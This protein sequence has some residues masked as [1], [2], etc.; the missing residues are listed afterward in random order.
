VTEVL[1]G[2]G[3]TALLLFFCAGLASTALSQQEQL[4]A[5]TNVTIQAQNNQKAAEQLYLQLRAVGLDPKRVYQVRDA[6]L[7]RDQLHISLDDGTIAFTQDVNGRITGAFFEG[8]GEILVV[9]PNQAERASMMLFTGAAILEERF[10][11]AYFR[12]NDDI[13]VELQPDLRPLPDG[14]DF[15]AKWDQTAHNLAEWDALRLFVTFSRFLPSVATEAPRATAGSFS[16]SDRFLHARVQGVKLGSFDAYYDSTASEQ[17]AVAQQKR[18]DTVNY[19]NVWAAFPTRPAEALTAEQQPKDEIAIRSY[20]IRAEVKPP[21]TLRA[22]ASLQ[23]EVLGGGA[24]AL[25]FELS[26]FLKVA[27]VKANG[28]PVELIQNQALEGSQLARRGNDILAVVF[29]QPIRTGQKMEL[30]FSYAGDVLSEAGGGLLYVGAR[31]TWYPNRGLAAADFDLQFQYPPGWTLLATGKRASEEPVKPSRTGVEGEQVSRW[32]TERPIPV[33]GFNL[34]RYTK[35]VAEAGKTT[36]ETYAATGVERSFPKAEPE[37]VVVP[38]VP[39]VRPQPSRTVVVA[40]PPPPSPARNAQVVADTA[41]RAVEFFSQRFGVFPYSTLELTQMPGLVSQGWPGLVFLSS[42]A[43]L[44]PE[45][46]SHL[47]LSAANEILDQQV[48]AHETAHQWWGDLVFW[49]GYRDQWMFEGLASY[50]SLMLLESEN[51]ANFRLAMEKYREDLMHKNKTGAVLKDAGPVTLGVRLSSSEF[52]EG[53]E[54]ISYG[55]GTW[56]FHMLRHIL[57]DSWAAD[58]RKS[59][60]SNQDEVEPFVRAL[61]RVRERYAGKPITTWQLLQVFAEDLPESDR[62]EG[63]KSLDWFYGGWVNG[64]ALP[65]FQLQGVRMTTKESSVAVSGTILQKDA[66]KELVTSVPIYAAMPGDRRVFLG[67]VFAD[68]PESSFRLTAPQGAKRLLVDPEETIL[69]SPH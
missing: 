53:Y 50:C 7:D 1:R 60:A 23:V 38:T 15:A 10:D 33:A 4:P 18:V 9:P 46:R 42:F 35:A 24:R 17:I 54:A 56:L 5:S 61:R 55:R 13:F 64:T 59:R 3:R 39:S 37:A 20:R 49:K 51:P 66:P 26:R 21:T 27:E 11:T 58:Q 8:D 30:T 25:L 43:F 62:Y 2:I 34:G 16:V 44:S 40:Q 12:F 69:T 19:Y 48:T 63:R 14:K 36:V 47:H 32:V 57:N 41:S 65:R 68:G 31:G 45:E 6:S 29:P 28:R 52:P 22:D 67:R